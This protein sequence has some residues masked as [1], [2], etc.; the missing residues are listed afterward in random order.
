M[1]IVVNK[2]IGGLA[3]AAGI[4]LVAGACGSS[5]GSASSN[6]PSSGGSGGS[7]ATTAA[8]AVPAPNK[9]PITLLFGSSGPAETAA[10][11]SA[12]KAY[13]AQTGIPVKVVPA[14][15]LTQELE[16]DFAGNQ[17]PNLFYL[18]P[19]LFQQYASKGVLYP[20]ASSLPNAGDF[21]PSLKS[22]FTYKGQFV[23]APKD[24]GPLSLYINAADWKAAGLTSADYPKTWSQL[25]SV[26]KKLTTGGRVGL[27]MDPNESRVDAFFYQD[28]GGIFNQSHTKVA[29]DSPA[30]VKALQFLQGM[31]KAGTLAFPSSLNESGGTNAF[32]AG[33]A[34]MVV[35]GNWLEGGMKADYPNVS[36]SV[37]PLP[38]G[39]GGTS[40]TLTFTNCWGVP[41]SNDNLGGTI[42]FVKFLTSP[43]QEMKFAEEFGPIP[44]LQTVKSQYLAQFPQN[45]AVLAGLSTGHPDISLAGSDQALTAYNSDLAELK[46]KSAQSIL[47][48]VQTNLQAVMSQDQS[49]N[50]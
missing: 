39:P 14:A 41:K 48:A 31:L 5:S 2:A 42:N 3:V 49:S 16:Q 43:A 24:G 7:T 8:G 4:A 9:K 22:A 18:S 25:E 23:C 1:T 36:Y 33:K 15:N 6:R 40:S 10:E 30:N 29:I 46:T 32:G 45:K 38:A 37:A 19:T 20:Y 47:Q 35:T 13:T 44:S 34:A 12:A 50:G 28:G 26:A 21:Y 17:P 27:T 11:T